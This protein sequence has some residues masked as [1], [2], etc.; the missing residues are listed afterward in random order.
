MFKEQ[1]LYNRHKGIEMKIPN[2]IFVVGCGGTGT[3]TTIMSAMLGTKIIHISDHDVIEL[4]NLSRLP[5]GEDSIGKLKTD[6]L[7]NFVQNI[8][9]DTTIYSYD[10]IHKESDLFILTG[11]VIFDCNDNPDIQDMIYKYCKD[12][13]LKYIGVGCNADHISILDNLDL[14]FKSKEHDPYE[15]T[16]I[17][18]IPPIIAASCALWNVIKNVDN[19]HKD[20]NVLK[21]ISDMLESKKI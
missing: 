14:V 4:H 12:G 3:W 20:I 10:G 16:P 9:P 13:G 8:R 17:F 1:D 21:K 6:V 19:K 2:E 11:D 7:R 18:L 5:F 15:I